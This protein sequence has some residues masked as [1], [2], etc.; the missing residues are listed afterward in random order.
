MRTLLL[1]PSVL[2]ALAGS[3]LVAGAVDERPWPRRVLLTNDDGAEDGGLRGLAAAFARVAETHVVTAQRNRSGSSNVVSVSRYSRSLL[4]GSHSW[5]TQKVHV[6]D[7]YPADCVVFGV[8]GLLQDTP[9]DLVVAGVNDGPNLSS[10]WF[11]SGTIGAARTAAYLGLPALAVSGLD[12]RDEK[13]VLAVSRWVVEVARSPLVRSLSPGQYLTISIPR[14][15]VAEI[16]GIKFVERDLPERIRMRPSGAAVENDPRR[17]ELWVVEEV[18]RSGP[19]LPDGD[20][21]WFN[22]NYIVVVPM[23]VGEMDREALQRLRVRGDALPVW[24]A[25]TR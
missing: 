4:V 23:F 12:D 15:P 22:R 3:P 10:D 6:V 16:R 8:H 20:V 19:R 17:R 11:L 21:T 14:V 1:I 7:G 2:L 13:M 5:G 9:P 18:V 25:G 24:D